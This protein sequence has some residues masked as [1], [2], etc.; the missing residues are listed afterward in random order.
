MP[1][2]TRAAKEAGQQDVDA[3]HMLCRR[4]SG[5]ESTKC[6]EVG[7]LVKDIKMPGG[8]LHMRL[9]DEAT[10]EEFAAAWAA[11]PGTRITPALIAM[12]VM[13]SEDFLKNR[14][15]ATLPLLDHL[16]CPPLSGPETMIVWTTMSLPRSLV[17]PL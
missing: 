1:Y 9:F 11:E 6:M 16:I 15:V 5:I 14:W 3:V 13:L 4:L 7:R 10:M 8:Y 12:Q 2:F 17:R